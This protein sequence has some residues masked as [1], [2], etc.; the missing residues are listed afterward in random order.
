VQQACD[1]KTTEVF[2]LFWAFLVF[3]GKV[4]TALNLKKQE[5][6]NQQS[7]NFNAMVR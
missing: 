7:R 6:N 5:S 1:L 2:N 4:Y 3:I